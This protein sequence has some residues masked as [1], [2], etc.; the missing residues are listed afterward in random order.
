MLRDRVS[1]DPTDLDQLETAWGGPV[2]PG[3]VAAFLSLPSEKRATALLRIAVL[4]SLTKG[5]R[6]SA[7]HQRAEAQRL[8]ISPQRLRT[9]MRE[10]SEPRVVAAVPHGAATKRRPRGGVA[11]GIAQRIIEKAVARDAFVAEPSVGRRIAA[12]FTRLGHSPPARMTIRRLLEE[13]RRKHPARLDEVGIDAGGGAEAVRPGETL[14][15][16]SVSFSARLGIGA[17]A[18]RAAALLLLDAG[19]GLIVAVDL[20]KGFEGLGRAAAELILHGPPV[21]RALWSR[22]R[23]IILAPP[24]PH[25]DGWRERIEATASRLDVTIVNGLRS[26]ARRWV[27]GAQWN[28]PAGLPIAPGAPDADP[29]PDWPTLSLAE[30]ER[31]LTISLVDRLDAIERRLDDEPRAGSSHGAADEAALEILA[32]F[33][34][35][36]Q[37]RAG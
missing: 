37:D 25:H 34:T 31:A 4:Q 36:D 22:P 2:P 12:V 13:E 8:G 23:T 35:A 10:W 6:P 29:D 17:D 24:L 16:T 21:L 5:A 7:E 11:R 18:R 9:L 33:T 15:V 32:L 1:S 27:S 28:A 30:Y 14:L 20:A 26:R 3:Q 19:S